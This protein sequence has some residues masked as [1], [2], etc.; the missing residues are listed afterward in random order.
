MA[1]ENIRIDQLKRKS[2]NKELHPTKD[3]ALYKS[4]VPTETQGR[5]YSGYT[6]LHRAAY[7]GYLEIAM[8]LMSYGA[9]LNARTNDCQLP[10]DVGHRNTEE[11]DHAIRDEHD[12]AWMRHRGRPTPQR[13]H[14]SLNTA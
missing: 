8:L 6:P 11:I 7:C 13:S 9:D 5:D 3:V 10:I 2:R 14:I 12:A 1:P 4:K